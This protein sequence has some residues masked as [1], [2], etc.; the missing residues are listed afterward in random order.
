MCVDVSL[1]KV[2]NDIVITLDGFLFFINVT[3]N[4][5]VFFGIVLI[6][7]VLMVR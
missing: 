5:E 3:E 6:I 4:D 1:L 7:V 2:V